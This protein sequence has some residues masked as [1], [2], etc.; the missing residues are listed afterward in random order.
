MRS[1]Y[2]AFTRLEIEYVKNTLVPQ[3]QKKFDV[4]KVKASSAKVTWKGLKILSTEKGGPEDQVG[5]VEFTA[6]YAFE[7]ETYE[8][9]EVSQ[10]R[11]EDN[12]QWLYV[13]GESHTHH[14]GESHHH[15]S[16]A[17]VV[18]TEAK[19]GRNDPC[20]CG[21]GKKYKKCCAA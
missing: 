12:G 8:Q 9:H 21:S 17:P 18:R 11:K 14:E 10:F 20:P 5:T 19:V 15:H 6:T 4:E 7:D 3:A 16:H 13:E 2:A 1:R